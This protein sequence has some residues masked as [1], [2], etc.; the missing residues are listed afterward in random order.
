[1]DDAKGW[2]V[3]RHP[4]FSILTP[5]TP[6]LTFPTIAGKAGGTIM[7]TVA[8]TVAGSALTPIIELYSPTG[9]RLTY[10]YAATGA[11]ITQ[12]N[13]PVDGTYVITVRDLNGYGTG[14]YAMTPVSI[15]PG[16][17]QNNGGDGGFI[18]SGTTRS[19]TAGAGDIDAHPFYGVTGDKVV[20]TVTESTAGSPLTPILELYGPNGARNGSEPGLSGWKVWV[21]LDSDGVLNSNERRGTWFWSTKRRAPPRALRGDRYAR[22]SCR[23]NPTPAGDLPRRSPTPPPPHSFRLARRSCTPVSRP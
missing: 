4:Q 11:T 23:L 3:S 20:I 15:G 22:C 13:L 19:S 7:A 6:L 8:E 2:S 9:A 5:P 17:S 1:M 16:I 12:F 10:A 18:P 21:D 14:G